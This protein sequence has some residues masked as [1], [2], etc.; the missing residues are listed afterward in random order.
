MA[1]KRP[2]Y[3]DHQFLIEADFTAEQNYHLDMRRRL[4]KLLYSHG[5]AEGLEVAKT[6]NKSVTV[7]PGAAIDRDG[8]EIILE[9][10]QVLDLSDTAQFGA[11]TVVFITAA[12]QEQQSDP[13]TATGAAGNTRITEQP[14]IQ[15]IRVAPPTDGRVVRLATFRMDESANVP[16]N[17]NDLFDG[18]V[19][20]PI[21][22]KGE[23]GPA[24]LDGV[25]NPG[26]NID[27]IAA[28]AIL[29][30]PDD[31]N[32]RIIIGEGHSA[33]TDNPHNTTAAQI[34]ALPAAD[35]DMRRRSQATI[36]FTQANTNGAPSTVNV[37]FQPKVIIIFGTCTANLSGRAYSGGIGAFVFLDPSNAEKPIVQRCFGFG[38]TKLSN[39]DWLFRSLPGTNILTA[40]IQ[41]Q[42]VAPTQGEILNVE[43][44]SITGTGLVATFSRST[45]GGA[46]LPSFN[47]TLNLL[48]MG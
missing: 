36:T 22:V 19:R 23:R 20:Q 11:G 14:L 26:G 15:A 42:G 43:V 17:I 48:C 9:A 28:Q 2:H 41:D 24:S 25:S 5:I 31:A 21:A 30:T 8:R 27:L 37:G 12:Y 39:T 34:G 29:I 4:N 18:G 6:T 44:S 33:R 1:I 47:I 13:S 45:I 40:N 35:F 46:P 38:I 3:F 32:N 7:R 10:N 16:G